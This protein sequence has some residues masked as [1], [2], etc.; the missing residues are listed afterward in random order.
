MP[1]LNLTSYVLHATSYVLLLNNDNLTQFGSIKYDS[2]YIFL[3]LNSHYVS[4]LFGLL[5]E[6]YLT[7]WCTFSKRVK[8]ISNN[9]NY[10]HE[11]KSN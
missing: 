7:L 2:R 4:L 1:C 10:N 8:I 11:K 9:D 6:D 3:V 5:D